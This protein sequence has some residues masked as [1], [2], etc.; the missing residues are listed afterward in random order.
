V[1]LERLE[2]MLEDM[3]DGFFGFLLRGKIQPLEIARRL[4]REAEEQKIITLNR[5]YIPNRFT[6]GLHPADMT[7]LQ[8]IAPE[9]QAEF[10]R[11]VGEWAI[12]RDYTVSG[13]IEVKLV[14]QEKVARSRMRIAAAIDEAEQPAPAEQPQRVEPASFELERLFPSYEEEDE[15]EDLEESPAGIAS[16]QAA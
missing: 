1:V 13:H 7:S 14:P 5:V 6:V 8:A 16:R 3:V 15:D 10:E 11:F 12:D 4:T 2:A 9:L